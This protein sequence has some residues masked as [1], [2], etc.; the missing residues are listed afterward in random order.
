MKRLVCILLLT[1][2][3]FPAGKAK[4]QDTHTRLKALFVYQFATLVDWP[5]EF[6]QGDFIIGIFGESPLFS[7]MVAKF[8]NKSVG[9]QAI[10][11]KN[12]LKI[13]DITNCHILFVAPE[14]SDKVAELVKKYRSK[15]TLIVTEHEGKLRDGA[16]INFVISN[17]KQSFEI[18][19]T[20]AVK[21]KLIVGAKLE[22]LAARVE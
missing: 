19:K 20:N 12:F 5:K 3:V 10:K 21:H 9:S 18:S 4:A 16:I 8:S 17:N 22:Q 6:K 13:T 7:E 15:S 11:I 2:L 1:F 14:M